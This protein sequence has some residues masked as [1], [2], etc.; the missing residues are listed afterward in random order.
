MR[1][2]GRIFGQ[3][4]SAP[5]FRLLAEN[6]VVSQ[7]GVPPFSPTYYSAGLFVAVS[8]E[9]YP[10]VYDLTS[11][12]A[13]RLAQR[14]ASFAEE[15]R[16]AAGVYAPFTIAE[17]NS[18]PLDYSVLDTCLSWPVPSPLHPPGQPVP[19]GA[20]FTSAPVLVLS[21][22]LDSLTPAEQGKE[23]A[24]LFPNATQVL[25]ANSFH[26]TALG[27]A[28]DCAS[29]IV[30]YFIENLNPGDTSCAA[31]IAEVRTISGFAQHASEVPAATPVSGNQGTVLD[32][33]VAAASA[34]TAGD[35]IARWWMN[36]SGSGVGSPAELSSTPTRITRINSSW[37]AW[38]G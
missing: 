7:S 20:T 8:C 13:A 35:A 4:N 36:L 14:K 26:V 16:A 32:L 17:F 9:D 28:D 15:E 23:A 27:D 1:P 3:G 31:Q 24:A 18:I 6:G 34:L 2:H 29:E 25:V 5:L 12:P 38:N 21:G 22:T 11:P 10:Q 33:R 19:P 37:L 30:R